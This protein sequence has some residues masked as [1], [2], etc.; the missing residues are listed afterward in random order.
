MT[1]STDLV[2]PE[3]TNLAKVDQYSRQEIDLIKKTVAKDSTDL[4]LRMFLHTCKLSGL[5]PLRKQIYFAKIKGKVVVMAAVDGLQ[6]RA[7]TFH[8]HAGTQAFAVCE[9]DEFQF[10][11]VQ[12]KPIKH[13]FGTDRGEPLGAWAKVER[14]GMTPFSA[15]VKIGDYNKMENNWTYMPTTMIKKVARMTAL[16]MAFPDKF[17]GIYSSEEMDHLRVES[18]LPNPEKK[19]L[20]DK[21]KELSEGIPEDVKKDIKER[22]LGLER[23][24]EL[25]N[26]AEWLLED[27]QDMLAG[28]EKWIEAT[29]ANDESE[30]AQ[31]QDPGPP[32]CCQC[33]GELGERTITTDEGDIC[34]ACDTKNK[35]ASGQQTL[36]KEEA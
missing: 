16:R 22:A 1:E 20:L 11:A 30:D 19:N 4:E 32:P 14:K 35:E 3:N 29:K 17:S 18:A 2:K 7:E 21:L 24:K 9:K 31:D 28:V 33:L 25:D 27:Y 13:I 26:G 10:D 5:D 36:I 23:I 6:A 34:A 12:G 8:D 15:Y